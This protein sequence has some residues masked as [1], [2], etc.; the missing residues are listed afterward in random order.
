MHKQ[1]GKEHTKVMERV[2]VVPGSDIV[3]KG[4]QLLHYSRT[5]FNIIWIDFGVGFCIFW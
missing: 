5:E 3:N 1:D 4:M 2:G